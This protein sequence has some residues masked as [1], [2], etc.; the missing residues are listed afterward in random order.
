[1]T[2]GIAALL[3]GAASAYG[4]QAAD[5]PRAEPGALGFVPEQVQRIERL[6]QEHVD[7]GELPGAVL[8]LARRGK[9]AAWRAFGWADLE[10]RRPM[11][12]DDLFRLA[13][14]TKIITSVALLTL[15]EEG[16]FALRDSVGDYLPEL[17]NLTVQ[18][19]DGQIQP[20]SRRLTIR[21]LLRHTSGYGYGYRDP[22]QSA[23]RRA[24]IL[25]P[26]PELDWSH[27]LTLDEWVAR[28][29]TVPLADEPGTRFEY[30]LSSDIAGLLI[31]R[32]SKQ[33]LDHFMR[34]R[35]F[36]PLEM[37]DTG[38]VVSD[39]KLDRLTSVYLAQQGGL[40]RLDRAETS[41]LGRQPKALSGGGGWDMLG[42]SGLVATAPDMFRLLQML[43]NDG[44]L[45]GAR[46]L[47]RSTVAMMR[48]NHLAELPV[49]ER[50]PGVGFGFGYAVVDDVVKHGEAASPGMMWWA[51]STN[52]HYW[53]DPGE[54]HIGLYFTQLQPFP[55]LDLMDVVRRLS[56]QSLE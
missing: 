32:L 39:E 55:Y 14:A 28:L 7:R 38:F 49:P 40:E 56:L 47:S 54:E 25:R 9:V 13:S 8:L 30:G 53:L 20:M 5:L 29:A 2:F 27:D 4:G 19:P 48:R 44:E 42:G 36:R 17:R 46:V 26:G 43:L 35:I 3:A 6:I 18:A 31:E 33:R 51:G 22:Q 24:G 12:P 21:D 15:Y 1:M 37:N 11:K 23:Y 41:P 50:S 16:K 52:V 10:S 45:E 34:D